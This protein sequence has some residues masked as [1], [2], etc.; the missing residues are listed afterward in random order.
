MK[1][2]RKIEVLSLLRELHDQQVHPTLRDAE[3]TEAEAQALADEGLALLGDQGVGEPI[4]RYVVAELSTK[5][6][7]FLAKQKIHRE[8]HV[9]SHTPPRPVSARIAGALGRKLWDLFWDILK[10]SLGIAVGWL[11][12]K[13]FR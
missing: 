3:L 7:A 1:E 10:V 12:R 8:Q 4:D 11:L 5:A 13:Y 6:Y 9:V 2:K